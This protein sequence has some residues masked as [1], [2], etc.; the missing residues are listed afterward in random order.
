MSVVLRLRRLVPAFSF[1]SLLLAQTAAPAAVLVYADVD[2]TANW[3]TTE[4]AWTNSGTPSVWISTSSA[5]FSNGNSANGVTL[6][7]G[8]NA[9]SISQSGAGT[10]TTISGSGLTLTLSGGGASPVVANSSGADLTFASGLTIQQSPGTPGDAQRWNAG[11]GS[12][13]IVNA[14]LSGALTGGLIKEGAGGLQLNAANSYSG[15]TYLSAG[16]LQVGNAT[17]LGTSTLT[18]QGGTLRY[19]LAIT[20]GLSTQFA[21]LSGSAAILD[22][23]GYDI[24]LGSAVTGTGGLVKQGSGILTMAAGSTY[25]GGTTVEAGILLSGAGTGANPFG[26]NGSMVT[27]KNGA[28]LD[29]NW[30]NAANYASAYQLTIEGKG[31]A[32]T[33]N[34][35]FGGYVGALTSSGTYNNTSIAFSSMLLTGDTTIS[36]RMGATGQRYGVPANIDARVRDSGGN[37]IANQYYTLTIVNGNAMSWRG[38]A[39]NNVYVGDIRLEQG[40]LWTD[41][42]NLGDNNFSLYIN[43]NLLGSTTIWGELGNWLGTRTIA[44]KTVIAGGLV[45][46]EGYQGSSGAKIDYG[47]VT[48]FTL[49]GQMT[50]NVS[51]LADNR[52]S[53]SYSVR[54]AKVTGQITGSGGL[55]YTGATAALT[56]WDPTYTTSATINRYS[57]LYLTNSTNNF[58]GTIKLDSGLIRMSDGTAS[59]KLGGGSNDFSFNTTTAPAILDLFG[60]SQS[61]G[62][63]NGASATFHFVQNNRQNTTSTL[64]VGSGGAS[65]SFAGVLRDYAA[66]PADNTA[67]TNEGATNAKLALV[68]ADAGQQVLTNVST[69]TGGTTITGGSLQV[70]TGATGQSTARLGS[71]FFTVNTGGRLEGNGFIGFTGLTSTVA[72]GGTLSVGT[73]TQTGLQYLTVDGTLNVAGT[74][75]FDLWGVSSGSGSLANSDYLTFLTGSSFSLGSTGVLNITA[76]AGAGDS[77]TWAVGTWFQLF[78]FGNVT[79]GNRSVALDNSAS[80]LLPALNSGLVQWDFSRLATEGRIYVVAKA[81]TQTLEFDP[82]DSYTGTAQW[83]TTAGYMAWDD[84]GIAGVSLQEWI[85]GANAVIKNSAS[86]SLSVVENVSANSLFQSV[87]GTIT[88]IDSANGSVLTLSGTNRVV[89]NTSGTTL[90]FGSGLTVDISGTEKEW[91]ADA[92]SPIVVNGIITGA[93]GSYVSGTVTGGLIKS[94]DGVLELRG[95]NTYSGVTR[96]QGGAVLATTAA[97]FGTSKVVF[98]GGTLRYGAAI[99]G[100]YASL[101]A[102]LNYGYMARLDTNGFNVTLDTA[103]S[104]SSGLTKLGTGILTVAAGSSYTGGTVVEAGI[105]KNGATAANATNPFGANGSQITVKSGAT[106]DVNWAD[107]SNYG[108]S[109]KYNLLVE[110]KGVADSSGT[111]AGGYVGAVVSSGSASMTSSPFNLITMTGDTT[112]AGRYLSTGARWGI[113]AINA[114]GYNITFVNANG[115]SWAVSS[116]GN[117]QN[118][119]DIYIEQQHVYADSTYFGDDNY[120]III[121]AS[122]PGATLFR[123]E[124]RRY[125]SSGTITKKITLNGGVVQYEGEPAGGMVP[126]TLTLAGQVTLMDNSTI[127]AN[128][129]NSS[130]VSRDI[131]ITGRLTGAGGFEYQGSTGSYNYNGTT[132]T[133]RYSVLTLANSAN[134]F[135]GAVNLIRGVIR[136]SDGAL[137]GTLGAS[138]NAFNFTT[139]ANISVL[140]LFGTSQ[141]IGALNGTSATNHFVQNNRA[142][143]TAILTVGN[144]GAS[145]SFAGVLRDYG[146][147]PSGN[148]S[149]NEA[150]YTGDGATGAKLALVKTGTGTQV[151]TGVNTFSGGTVV[152]GGVL[153]VGVGNTG[154]STATLGSGG[155][156]VNNGGTL[157]GNGIL[158]VAGTLNV[159]NVGGILA[160]GTSTQTAA[161]RLDIYGGLTSTGTLSFNL[162]SVTLGSG[163]TSNSD[164]LK[165]FSNEQITLGGTL[166][167]SNNTGTLSTTWTEGTWFQLVDWNVVATGNRSVNFTDVSFLPSL[168]GGLQWDVSQ[169]ATDGRIYVVVPEP[170]RAVLVLMGLALCAVRR[171]RA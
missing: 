75:S 49:S 40:R 64:T 132:P 107:A 127:A 25:T 83:K 52:I 42:D 116:A 169:F 101:F 164:T 151:L 43:A 82:A 65:G 117:A 138:S 113:T 36:G 66:L 162:F 11:A 141:S 58:T 146:A 98:E 53:A 31:V 30:S 20:G 120:S 12:N 33:S 56:D 122:K 86:N 147:L 158:G 111:I 157:A 6:T 55:R 1:L 2:G 28:T 153:Q 130:G 26:A 50:L 103:L 112:F 35:V 148:A 134:D 24:I 32:D 54:D 17:A 16:V 165:F 143:T 92:T 155:F 3:N 21:T 77:T 79:L 41:A 140:D 22:T 97:A 100:G 128:R 121:N 108:G 154:Q 70:G 7:E 45:V 27:V 102:P 72:S 135:T 38:A 171:R 76:K 18:F 99:T 125:S 89:S 62:A 104:G 67:I 152:N 159:V 91:Y 150:T 71:G 37:V 47:T 4:Q 46:L 96:L 51:A 118:V 156:T 34:T 129:L 170:G 110:G 87:T 23:N 160:P 166:A 137:N 13:I 44:K 139:P 149:M 136:M 61:I 115:L 106:L 60:T 90:T 14:T 68:K 80:W 15:A 5:E 142:S 95:A 19:G 57:V 93:A 85:N 73:S 8:I 161:Q 69:Y 29:L 59:G 81:A 126:R 78:D 124:L 133:D 119:R 144:G 9:T 74:L 163:S 114:S 168:A 123:G 109:A 145:G 105:L 10:K 167:V 63:L 84:T 48:T 94:G 39:A 88:T 131:K